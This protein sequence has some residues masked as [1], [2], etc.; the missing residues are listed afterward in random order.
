MSGGKQ[1][2]C[3]TPQGG[4]VSPMLANLYMNRF[5]KHWRFTGCGEAFRAHVISYADDFVILSRGHAAEA[6][7]WT[8]AVMTKLGLTLNEAKTSLKDARTGTLRLPWLLVR[9][10]SLSQGWPLV[11]GREPIQ[12]ERA[13][14]QGQDRRTPGT[15]QQRVM[16]RGARP[17]EQPSARLVGVLQLWHAL[18]GLSRRST[19]TSTTACDTSSQTAQGATGAARHGS[20]TT[21]SSVNLACCISDACTLGPAVG[22][23]GEAGRKAGCRKSARPV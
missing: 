14:A 15:R 20:P 18:A 4:V 19:I 21:K 7:A 10:A 1:S 22:R 16:A 11:S 3:G 12:E 6:L 5:L 13:A 17:A 8:K 23:Y 2:T 9:T